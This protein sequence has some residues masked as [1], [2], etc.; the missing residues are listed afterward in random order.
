MFLESRVGGARQRAL[1]R[2]TSDRRAINVPLTL[3]SPRRG[4]GSR[5][6]VASRRSWRGSAAGTYFAVAATFLVAF[7]LAWVIRRPSNDMVAVDDANVAAPAL[8]AAR[9]GRPAGD[10]AIAPGGS[11][12]WEPVTLV[13][14]GGP[15]GSAGN[16]I[17]SSGND[18]CRR[19]GT[20]S[21]RARRPGRPAQRAERMGHR[22]EEHRQ[23]IPVDSATVVRWSCRSMTSNSCPSVRG[24]ISNAWGF[25]G[26]HSVGPA[27][28]ATFAR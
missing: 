3:P 14:D 16:R 7:G 6:E 17:A 1:D 22:V 5:L 26:G 25:S 28:R 2:A 27:C 13:M 11:R 24:P 18:K 8:P 20:R 21:A 9:R 4:E 23:F 10:T 19:A 12:P 15:N